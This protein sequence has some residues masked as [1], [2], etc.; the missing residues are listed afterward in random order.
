MTLT[1]EEAIKKIEST[2]VSEI[3]ISMV[4][5]VIAKDGKSAAEESTIRAHKAA[6][7]LYTALFEA[8]K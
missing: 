7:E 1:K 5:I 3:V 6:E 4:S 2:L 8:E